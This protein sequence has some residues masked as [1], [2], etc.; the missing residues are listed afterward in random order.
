M[1]VAD[2]MTVCELEQA[3]IAGVDVTE[4]R[5][6]LR[7][8]KNRVIAELQPYYGEVSRDLYRITD[9]FG[10][11]VPGRQ[12]VF[13]TVKFAFGELYRSMTGDQGLKSKL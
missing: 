10:G 12:A 5:P 6:V 1:S 8:Y 9:A 13:A 4:G 2:L 7:E 3:T 11:K